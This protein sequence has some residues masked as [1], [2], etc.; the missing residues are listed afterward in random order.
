MK[1]IITIVSPD[2]ITPSMFKD[3]YEKIYGDNK[4]VLVRDINFLYS[5]PIQEAMF[6]SS[7][8]EA[9]EKGLSLI[10]KYSIKPNTDLSKYLIPMCF[11]DSSD[12]VIKFDMFSTK[13]EVIKDK[14]DSL[15]I[16]EKWEAN[17]A[18]KDRS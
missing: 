18:S 9:D 6:S 17:I 5:K 16:L 8:K 11:L 14:F 10:I 15:S 1:R 2:K 4:I 12:L 13:P 3:F 7:L